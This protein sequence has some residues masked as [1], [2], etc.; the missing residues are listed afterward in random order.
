MCDYCPRGSF[1][2]GGGQLAGFVAL[3]NT[4]GAARA[5]V[6]AGLSPEDFACATCPPTFTT[7]SVGAMRAASCACPEGT[8]WNRRDDTCD[9]CPRG[10]VCPGG[11]HIP[12]VTAGYYGFAAASMASDGKFHPQ[13]RTCESGECLVTGAPWNMKTA[14]VDLDILQEQET[15]KMAGTYDKVA[16]QARLQDS[17]GPFY[18][19]LVYR[20]GSEETCPA[21]DTGR[22]GHRTTP[23]GDVIISTEL[24]PKGEK[25][26]EEKACTVFDLDALN[27]ETFI[28]DKVRPV[29][30]FAN[31][32]AEKRTGV[33]CGKCVEGW[34]GKTECTECGGL[35]GVIAVLLVVVLPL[36]LVLFYYF[37]WGG[38]AA[39]TVSASMV[40]VSVLGMMCFVLQTLAVFDTFSLSWPAGMAW[41]F[42]LS[43]LFIFDLDD[44]PF[45]CLVGDSFNAKF[46][47]SMM[48]PIIVVAAMGVG[49]AFTHAMK[50]TPMMKERNP[51]QFNE[52]FSTLGMIFTALYITLAKVVIS[53]YECPQNP[54]APAT[55]QKFLDV[56]CGSDTHAEGVPAM[57][58][59]VLL[60]V[61]GFYVLNLSAIH[62]A[63]TNWM[64]LSFRTRYRYLFMRFR[65]ESYHWGMMGMTRNLLVALAAMVSDVAV[66]QLSWCI[67]M[68]FVFMTCTAMR[69]PWR[70]PYLNYFDVVSAECVG[71]IGFLGLIFATQRSKVLLLIRL[72]EFTTANSV[73]ERVGLF[74]DFFTVMICVFALFFF[75]LVVWCGRSMM[76][77]ERQRQKEQAAQK[78]AEVMGGLK[79]VT[80]TGSS[81]REAMKGY[82]RDG[83][84]YEVVAVKEMVSKL[85]REKDS[86]DAGGRETASFNN[87]KKHQAG[88][89][90]SNTV[91]AVVDEPDEDAELDMALKRIDALQQTLRKLRS[92]AKII[93]A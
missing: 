16:W 47:I 5:A 4:S 53:F 24:C 30:P 32:C 21:L 88:G 59:G 64:N 69:K 35:G 91:T 26:C 14:N 23:E 48:L 65:L 73:E 15:E 52:A 56:E 78:V 60:Y 42:T 89:E 51:I 58:V 93:A 34:F 12:L 66:T 39:T 75:S 90:Q 82:L 81:F 85:M 76:P 41:L 18:G 55:M 19:L 50:N 40:L 3:G 77:A 74:T 61:V 27:G 83:T 49:A 87:A 80:K 6:Y 11:L 62:N 33:G 38:A 7:F 68:I 54:S 9:V 67:V 79:T 20:C 43:R 57:I 37:A 92:G 17:G 45:S 8:V 22:C 10:A 25:D 84:P 44:L 36:V 46:T 86:L 13:F 70:H 2:V 29:H 72:N 28:R 31:S 71:I 1:N 63:P